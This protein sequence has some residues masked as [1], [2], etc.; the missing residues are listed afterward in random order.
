[1]YHYMLL[2]FL[3]SAAG[4][5]YCTI[6]TFRSRSH[7]SSEARGVNYRIA[8]TKCHIEI[9]ETDAGDLRSSNVLS[10]RRPDRFSRFGEVED[11]WNHWVMQLRERRISNKTARVA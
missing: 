3:A 4:P 8:A 6:S 11:S 5:H 2:P 1:M 7:S 9:P 10:I